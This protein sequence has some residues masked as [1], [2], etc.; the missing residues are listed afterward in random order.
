VNLSTCSAVSD[1]AVSLTAPEAPDHGVAVVSPGYSF[2]TFDEV[3]RTVQDAYARA[4]V[5][6]PRRVLAV[7]EVHDCVSFGGR[8]CRERR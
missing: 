2:T 8:E 4:G 7:A 1:T 5:E 3:M 6:D